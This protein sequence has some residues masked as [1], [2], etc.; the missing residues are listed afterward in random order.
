MRYSKQ[1]LLRISHEKYEGEKNIQTKLRK[2]L[3]AC[4]LFNCLLL[5]FD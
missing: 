5:V 4:N 3:V 2:S 1:K